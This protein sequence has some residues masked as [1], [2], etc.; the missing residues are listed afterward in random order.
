VKAGTKLAK[1]ATKT[2]V[3]ASVAKK[4]KAKGAKITEK[5]S[6]PTGTVSGSHYAN[7]SKVNTYGS[8]I[9]PSKNFS[10]RTLPVNG[11]NLVRVINSILQAH[12]AGMNQI[13]LA[14]DNKNLVALAACA[15]YNDLL[16]AT[17]GS[18]SRF[19]EVPMFYKDIFDAISPKD[20]TGAKY[21]GKAGTAPT[22]YYE[23]DGFHV[24]QL[25]PG[26]Y[27]GSGLATVQYPFIVPVDGDE[28]TAAATSMF[29]SFGA[30]GHRMCNITTFSSYYLTDPS[31]FCSLTVKVADAQNTMTLASLE[32]PI[33][34]I[35][36]AAMGI[37]SITDPGNNRIPN[38]TAPLYGYGPSYVGDRIVQFKT[39]PAGRM[40]QIRLTRVDAWD[41]SIISN[42]AIQA[43]Y[44]VW[45][46]DNAGNLVGNPWTD[47]TIATNSLWVIYTQMLM[48][49]YFL[50]YSPVTHS[51]RDPFGI[52]FPMPWAMQFLP[53]DLG[54]LA[55]WSYPMIVVENLRMLRPYTRKVRGVVTSFYPVPSY[56]R[57]GAVEYQVRPWEKIGGAN[58]PWSATY[59][60]DQTTDGGIIVSLTPLGDTADPQ[61]IGGYAASFNSAM[62]GLQRNLDFDTFSI[63]SNMM[64]KTTLAHMTR[65]IY[66]PLNGVLGKGKRVDSVINARLDK[67]RTSLVEGN[68]AR[69]PKP[70]MATQAATANNTLPLAIMCDRPILAS[71][72]ILFQLCIPIAIA[73]YDTDSTLDEMI[74]QQFDRLACSAVV[75]VQTVGTFYK[76]NLF[77]TGK[78]AAV[79]QYGDFAKN[80]LMQSLANDAEMGLGGAIG[81]GIGWILTKAF[82]KNAGDKGRDFTNKIV[83]KYREKL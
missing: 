24:G 22:M 46:Q 68:K 17:I 36:T 11:D 4:V 73:I 62:P 31:A 35:W 47:V 70:G 18:K 48:Q 20:V 37:F 71:Y 79:T 65:V 57:N 2:A 50:P 27:Q 41:L 28:W 42:G 43:A 29:S 45:V 6:L 39:G 77:F 8:E 26:G 40:D 59:N 13:Q 61:S 25:D 9:T 66:P 32:V 69:L 56:S 72:S 33:Q 58:D 3:K 49:G 34:S 21:S 1:V 5:Q 38:Y 63:A 19:T 12:I 54:T 44:D 52:Y 7:A 23:V 60:Y 78:K 76:D 82:G 10:S 75:P 30:A 81:S 51:I 74:A 80:E 16:G 83:D 64:K 67:L 53:N 55:G 15:M 14:D